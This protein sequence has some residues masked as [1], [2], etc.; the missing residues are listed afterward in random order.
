[1]PANAALDVYELEELHAAA[2]A[3]QQAPRYAP[4]RSPSPQPGDVDYVDPDFD[5]DNAVIRGADTDD[6]ELE[7]DD[8]AVPPR[9]REGGNAL[10]DYAFNTRV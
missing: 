3:K 2:K 7:A 5:P 4:A 8:S 1:M 10:D 6:D 9:P